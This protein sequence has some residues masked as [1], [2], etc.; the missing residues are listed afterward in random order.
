MIIRFPM[1]LMKINFTKTF[2]KLAIFFILSSLVASCGVYKKVD[3]R[4]VPINSVDRAEKN[5][6]EGRGFR[7]FDQN[8]NRGGT[9]E[10]AT[11]NPLWRA[12]LDLVDF[13]PLS[14]VD[15]SGGIIIT[16]WFNDGNSEDSLKITIRFLAN[17]IRSDALDVQ[18]HKKNCSTEQSCKIVKIDSN[19]VNEIKT[20][21]L[22]KAALIKE[23]IPNPNENFKIRRKD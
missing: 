17:E 1:S 23:D 11:S 14:N 13:T 18:L 2:F 15:Y 10:F 7:V 4:K 6:Q 12:S 20:E 19:L 22:K 21:I 16:D 3:T 8:R 5:I 9:F